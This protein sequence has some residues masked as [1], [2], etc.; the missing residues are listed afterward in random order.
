[1]DNFNLGNLISK[2]INYKPMK[3]GSFNN[4]KTPSQPSSPSPNPAPQNSAR[5]QS[6]SSANIQLNSFESTDRSVYIKDLMKLPK[7][8][9]E[10]LYMLQRNLNQI[11][12]NRMFDEQMAS[13]KN[14]LSQTQ[15]QILAQ[16]EGLNISDAQKMLK[17]QMNSQLQ[18]SLRNLQ[19]SSSQ[20]INLADIANLIQINGKDA[21]TKLILAMANAS[22]QG[23]TDLSQLKDSAK[24]INASIALA[25]QENPAQTLKTLMLL[26]LPWLPLA[27]GIGFDLEIETG[28]DSEEADSILVVTIT[29][30]NYGV[31]VA[32]LILESQNSVHVMVECSEKFPKDELLLRIES[33][34]KHYSM[35]SVISF[36]T[37]SAKSEPHTAEQTTAKI[38]MS[39][40]NEISPYLL[41]MAHTII[42][43]TIEID[44]NY[45]G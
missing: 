37:K 12:F 42:R 6:S 24:L 31:I 3:T 11:Q 1:M 36:E 44:R 38:N 29:T 45:Q 4:P 14:L 18:T 28:S 2:Y 23:I 39:H 16:L 20:M 32:T 25:S 13:R 35:Q 41:L 26:Y 21:V 5:P 10:L 34:Q 40:T 27:D 33:E 43:H 7:N 15:A 9:N 8:M 22:K 17:S 30:I 19:L